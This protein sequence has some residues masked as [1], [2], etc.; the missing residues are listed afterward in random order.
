LQRAM[1]CKHHHESL[2][3]CSVEQGSAQ[4]PDTRCCQVLTSPP[5][6]CMRRSLSR[7]ARTHVPTYVWTYIRTSVRKSTS[8]P[9]PAPSQTRLTAPGWCTSPCN[10]W[11]GVGSYRF[12]PWPAHLYLLL[13]RSRRSLTL[14]RR[15]KL[16][17]SMLSNLQSPLAITVAARG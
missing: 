6:L 12:P 10:L 11:R 14:R 2:V 1:P 15:L 4:T 5:L 17:L 9:P 7:H 13:E 8:Q 3:T 16:P